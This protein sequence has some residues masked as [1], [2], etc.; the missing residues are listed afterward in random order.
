MSSSETESALKMVA[1]RKAHALFADLPISTAERIAQMQ[2]I[3][4]AFN[5][6]CERV[7]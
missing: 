3:E 7:L 6:E 1:R 2:M 5:E 4:Q